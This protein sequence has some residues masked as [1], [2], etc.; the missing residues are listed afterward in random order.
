MSTR[1]PGLKQLARRFLPFLNNTAHHPRRHQSCPQ[2]ICVLGMHR[3]GTS[4]LTGILQR[5]GVELGEVFTENPFNKRGNREHPR[6]MDLNEQLLTANGGA[7]DA[8]VI[9][10]HW[11]QTQVAEGEAIITQI[12]GDGSG[13]WGF[14]DPRALFTL[15][16]WLRLMDSPQFIGTFRHPARVAM[17]LRHRNNMAISD[18]MELWRSYNSRLLALQTQYRFP[19]VNFDLDQRAYLEDVLQKLADIGLKP[20]HGAD[21]TGFFDDTLR[22]QARVATTDIALPAPVA[23]LYQQLRQHHEM[24]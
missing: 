12:S 21:A 5:S 23:E 2:C 13:H 10:D 24:V 18:G 14:K 7:W 6:V 8:P 3:S 1:Q 11:D 9:V 19:L 4:C 22:N 20:G 16:F 17:S 15:P